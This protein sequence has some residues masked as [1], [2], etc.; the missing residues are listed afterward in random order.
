MLCAAALGIALGACGGSD[1]PEQLTC[2][3]GTHDDGNGVCVRDNALAVINPVD[4]Y[5]RCLGG[6][7]CVTFN[8]TQHFVFVASST[9]GGTGTYGPQA[10]IPAVP[11]E[12]F[13]WAAT[14]TD[15]VALTRT[16]GASLAPFLTLPGIVPNE[17][18]TAF[19]SGATGASTMRCTLFSG[20]IPQ[21]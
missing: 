19:V 5:W 16:S 8:C 4:T 18:G 21:G 12:S 13:T 3:A 2:G 9:A 17:N 14:S 11:N 15:S 7:G 6:P 1:S 10:R 20:A